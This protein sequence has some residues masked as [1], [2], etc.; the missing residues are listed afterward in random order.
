MKLCLTK[1]QYQNYEYLDD[2]YTSSGNVYQTDPKKSYNL[3]SSAR[4]IA[5]SPKK[6][7]VAPTKQWH[8]PSL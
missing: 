2:F 4:N 3:R 8:D 5:Q 1:D 7:V 6:K